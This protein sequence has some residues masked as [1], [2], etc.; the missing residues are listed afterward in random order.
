MKISD[1]L[2]I[3]D[4][5]LTNMCIEK[6][7]FMTEFQNVVSTYKN[8]KEALAHL[9]SKAQDL[10]QVLIFLDLKMPVLDGWGFLDELQKR[11][12]RDK[13]NILIMSSSTALSDKKKSK[14]Y[15]QVM[16]YLEKPLAT[17]TLLDI[18]DLFKTNIIVPN[19]A[20]EHILSK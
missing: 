18:I 5:H 10:D 12:F 19:Y 15:P 1:I 6:I 14:K 11:G 9:D 4:D 7:I 8:G 13:T 3:D 2:V 17:D 16:G 20:M